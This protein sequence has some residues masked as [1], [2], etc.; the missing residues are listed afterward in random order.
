MSVESDLNTLLKA[1]CPRVFPDVAPAGTATPYVTWQGI[2][3]ESV[4]FLDNTTGDKRN[5]FMQIN[6]WSQT[7]LQ[8]LQTIRD[9][10]NAMRA[11]PTFVCRPSGEPISQYEEDTQLYGAFQRFDIWSTR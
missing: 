9:I 4:N 8:A 1:I 6:V 7:R 5:T 2:G 3:G 11:A 10:E